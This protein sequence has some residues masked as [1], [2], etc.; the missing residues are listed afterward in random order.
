MQ[1]PTCERYVC[2]VA[3]HARR[4]K[5]HTVFLFFTGLIV[6][7]VCEAGIT[8]GY[9]SVALG[10]PRQQSAVS[11]K[12]ARYGAW[13]GT[14]DAVGRIPRRTVRAPGTAI[15]SSGTPAQPAPPA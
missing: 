2:S 5:G 15:A 11:L 4:S 12:A 13:G 7:R 1:S 3:L 10:G 9:R 6:W 14:Y 8:R